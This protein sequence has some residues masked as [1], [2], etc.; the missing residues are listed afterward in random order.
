MASL[1]TSPPL[2]AEESAPRN[3]WLVS[4]KTEWPRWAAKYG[5]IVVLI[6]VIITSRLLYSRFLAVANI[7]NVFSQNADLGLISIGTTIVLIAGGFDL[8]VGSTYALGAVVAA[9]L[10]LSGVPVVLAIIVA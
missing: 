3:S 8:S 4:A 5:M 2:I 6:V 7:R 1:D 9:K 10:S